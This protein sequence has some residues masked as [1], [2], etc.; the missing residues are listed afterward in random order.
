MFAE[1]QFF[2]VST[3]TWPISFSICLSAL[4]WHT[5]TTQRR[6]QKVG[7]GSTWASPP[8]PPPPSP[9]R[10]Q[11]ATPHVTVMTLAAAPAA[12]PQVMCPPPPVRCPTQAWH[13]TAMTPV[14]PM[15][16]RRKN[17]SVAC[18]WQC[19]ATSRAVW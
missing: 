13:P 9:A 11:A 16:W 18:H 2:I 5:A 19:S 6:Q 8:P 10:A 12:P 4:P 7:C 15:F 17:V 14:R 3:D 1:N